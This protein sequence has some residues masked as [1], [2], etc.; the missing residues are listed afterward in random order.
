MNAPSWPSWLSVDGRLRRIKDLGLVFTWMVVQERTEPLPSVFGQWNRGTEQEVNIA[1]RADA[2]S[3]F[4]GVYPRGK[5]FFEG[6]RSPA[7]LEGLTAHTGEFDH[8]LD[9]AVLFVKE[10]EVSHEGNA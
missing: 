4:V 9:L 2:K 1:L 5:G 3:S 6:S 8:V 10:R 7:E